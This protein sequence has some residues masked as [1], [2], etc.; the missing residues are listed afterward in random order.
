MTAVEATRVRTRLPRWLVAIV[1]Q[2]LVAILNL[3]LSVTVTQVAGVA[4]L[5]RFAVVATTITLCMGV[6]RLLV[7]DPWLASRT[8]SPTPIP[9]L[10]WLVALAA[11]LAAA[12][13]TGVVLISCGGDS[14]WLVAVPIAAAV[15]V[16]DFGR[17]LCFRVDRATGAFASDLAVLTGAAA[18]FGIAALLGQAGLTAVLVAWL[19]G[20]VIGV[21]VVG[22]QVAGPTSPIGALTWWRAHCRHLATR[23]AFDTVAYMVGVSGSLYLLAYVGTQR[24]VGVVR[25][26][27]TMFSPAALVV[28]GLTMWLVPFLAN[29]SPGQADRVRVRATWWL[30]AGT[31]PLVLLAVLLGSWFAEL[32]FG[33]EQG[34]GVAPLTMAALSTL[35]MAVAAPWVAAARVSGHYLPIAW[36][37]AGASVVTILGMLVLPALRSTTGYLGLLAFQNA[38]VATAAITIGVRRPAASAQPVAAQR[39]DAV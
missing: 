28:T 23:L 31:L 17:Y 15:V 39:P 12:V 4:T 30:L 24:D 21:L 35:A 11:G 7:T 32:V 5:G 2:G 8:A 37:R 22:G 13:T 19:A 9:Q 33:V 36:S 20:L 27:Q 25:I 38:T 3:A 10:R 18:A 14:R 1:D 16:Q 6:A 26:V 29:R 34:P